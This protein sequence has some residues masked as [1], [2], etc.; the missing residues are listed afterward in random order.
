MNKQ[1]KQNINYQ[2]LKRIR[3]ENREQE[4]RLHRKLISF[5]KLIT[6][7]RKKYNRKKFNK[8]SLLTD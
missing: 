3:K 6:Q 8:K 5:R 7:N 1:Q 2:V 4:I